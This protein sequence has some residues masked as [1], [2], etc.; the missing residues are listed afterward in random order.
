M[1]TNKIDRS[2][3]MQSKMLQNF[4]QASRTDAQKNGDAARSAAAG[5]CVA[6][7]VRSGEKLEISDSARKLSEMRGLLDAGKAALAKEPDIRED[8]IAAAKQRISS[9]HYDE[10]RVR[11]RFAEN[12]A[13][14]LEKIGNFI[15]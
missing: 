14:T 13:A 10:P 9:G 6:D 8:R 12:L 11:S 1:A 15:G 4:Q 5:S 2:L 7:A 3:N